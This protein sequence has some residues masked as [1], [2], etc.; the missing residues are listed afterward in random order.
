MTAEKSSTLMLLKEAIGNEY[1]LVE[2]RLEQSLHEVRAVLTRCPQSSQFPVLFLLSSL[3]FLEAA[4]QMIEGAMDGEYLGEDGWT[5]SDFLTHIR[6]N[7]HRI[8]IE[9][10]SV[11]GRLVKTEISLSSSGLLEITTRG[12]GRSADRW[13]AAV[14]GQSHLEEVV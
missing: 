5:P 14:Q 4:P 2:S 10:G 12:R 13:L 9:L 6:F 1:F 7:S 11:R 3:A 8:S